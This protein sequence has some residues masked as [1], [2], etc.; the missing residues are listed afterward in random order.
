MD[1]LISLKIFDKYIF[2]YCLWMKILHGV[3]EFLQN[4]EQ[5]F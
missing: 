2:L 4:P 1:I 3:M 5:R